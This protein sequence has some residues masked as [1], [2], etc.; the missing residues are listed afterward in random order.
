M[1]QKYSENAPKNG[2]IRLKKQNTNKCGI[3]PTEQLHKKYSKLCAT[4]G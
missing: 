4:K 1:V 2:T 3:L